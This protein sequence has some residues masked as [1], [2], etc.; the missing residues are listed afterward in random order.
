MTKRFKSE[1]AGTF[2]FACIGLTLATWQISFRLGAY[3]EVFYTDYMS[4]WFVSLAVLL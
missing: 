2:Y 1:E 4:I 3:G